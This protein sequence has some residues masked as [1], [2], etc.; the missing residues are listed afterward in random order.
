MHALQ[1]WWHP[2]PKYV[3]VNNEVSKTQLTLQTFQTTT[4]GCLS[5]RAPL[6]APLLQSCFLHS[7]EGIDPHDHSPVIS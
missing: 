7:P 3:L 5:S 4:E 1:L 6:G 2:V